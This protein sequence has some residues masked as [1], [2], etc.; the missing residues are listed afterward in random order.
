MDEMMFV[1]EKLKLFI[2]GILELYNKN[3]IYILDQDLLQQWERVED[4][5]IFEKV[6]ET[7]SHNYNELC[8]CVDGAFGIETDDEI[9]PMETGRVCFIPPYAFHSEL[10]IKN[11][12]YSSIWIS[13]WPDGSDLHLSGQNKDGGYFTAGYFPKAEFQYNQL[14]NE[15][16]WEAGHGKVYRAEYIK[17]LILQIL[18][19][20]SRM[21]R[22]VY[23]N[24]T[25][26][27]D[28]KRELVRQVEKYV[29]MNFWR[30]VSLNGIATF[31]YISP[32]YLNA[33]F[34]SV[35]GK[36]ITQYL[37]DCKIEKAKDDLVYGMQKISVIAERLGYYDQYHFCKAFKKETGLTPS[38]YRKTKRKDRGAL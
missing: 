17:S 9:V 10:P 38:Q 15:L 30:D 26:D 31:F 21:A 25:G 22:A 32:N 8:L 28:P 7:E 33:L 2:D 27:A 12:D 3:W 34:K 1:M 29:K 35:M 23:F 37:T 24:Q 16:H 36:T 14:L 13:V 6:L 18:I 20:V 4:R 11:Q 19:H 5:G